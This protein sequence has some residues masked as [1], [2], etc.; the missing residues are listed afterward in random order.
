ME[1]MR[2]KDD[3]SDSYHVFELKEGTGVYVR[4]KKCFSPVQKK[5]GCHAEDLGMENI[6][7]MG[8]I[9]YKR[10]LI[11]SEGK[12]YVKNEGYLYQRSL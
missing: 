5:E 4:W 3:R 2:E 8:V 1:T 11:C 7:G 9:S 6:H 12:S 10:S